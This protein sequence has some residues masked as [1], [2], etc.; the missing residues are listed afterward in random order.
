MSLTRRTLLVALG[1]MPLASCTMPPSSN[2]RID[3]LL[4]RYQGEGPGAA[5]AVIREGVAEHHVD[6]YANLEQRER[7]TSATNFRLA[8]V[9][10]QFTAAAVLLL[11][12]DG[13]L[14]LDDRVRQWLP[15]LPAAAE[16]V[17]LR[18]LLTHTSGLID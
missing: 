4:K 8:S 5:V 9:T 1:T 3:E 18:H 10:K 15:S 13:K 6:G 14:A 11:L 2:V 16:T 7:I 12:E 17:T